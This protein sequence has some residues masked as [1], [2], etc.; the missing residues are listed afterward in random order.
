MERMAELLSQGHGWAGAAAALR[1]RLE[2][3]HRWAWEHAAE[4]RRLWRAA[5]RAEWLD[6]RADAMRVLR[7]QMRSAD[8]ATAVPAALLLIAECRR[9]LAEVWR[10]R[11]K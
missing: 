8:P 9:W 4:W 1:V 10:V 7:T 2:T 11:K 5:E 3:C 6:A